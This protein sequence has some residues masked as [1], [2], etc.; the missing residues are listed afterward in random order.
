MIRLANRQL[1]HIE[2]NF[3]RPKGAD[4]GARRSI[5]AVTAV[6]S[7]AGWRELEGGCKSGDSRSESLAINEPPTLFKN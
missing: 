4:H 6:Y 2:W 5:H 1:D 3:R 7:D